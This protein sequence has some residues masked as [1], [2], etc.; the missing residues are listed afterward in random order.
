MNLVPDMNLTPDQEVQVFHIVQE[1][2]ANVSKHAR[3]QQVRISVEMAADQYLVTIDDD[4]IGLSST[5]NTGVG[6]H[7][8]MNIMRERAQRLGGSVDVVSQGTRIQL[9]FPAASQ[10]RTR[11]A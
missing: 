11:K 9:K 8:G 2:L 1:A 5:G 3:A 4:G 10:R 7:F 6:M